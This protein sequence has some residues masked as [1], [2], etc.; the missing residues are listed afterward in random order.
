MFK[1]GQ[2][3]PR[4]FL[5]KGWD[6]FPGEMEFPEG[7]PDRGGFSGWAELSDGD[8]GLYYRMVL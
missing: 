5:Q 1:R 8:P 7:A 3:C 2:K 4:L 6:G